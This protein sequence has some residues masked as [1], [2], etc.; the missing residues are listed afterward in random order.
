[1]QYK[2][3]LLRAAGAG[4]VFDE[5]ITSFSEGVLPCRVEFCKISLGSQPEI[6]LIGHTLSPACI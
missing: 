6:P 4:V 2:V 5:H 1:M 3:N